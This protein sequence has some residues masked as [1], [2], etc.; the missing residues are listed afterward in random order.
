MEFGWIS[1]GVDMMIHDNV[2][3][4]SMFIGLGFHE[5]G[6]IGGFGLLI[7]VR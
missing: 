5:T 1:I 7:F 2:D 3:F 6:T 4:Y